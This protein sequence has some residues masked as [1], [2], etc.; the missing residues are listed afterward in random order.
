MII[1]LTSNNI[2][3]ESKICYTKS[4]FSK[5]KKEKIQLMYV[6]HSLKAYSLISNR[7]CSQNFQNLNFLHLFIAFL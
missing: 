2:L 5:E 6:S 1:F 7:G 3:V 4:H